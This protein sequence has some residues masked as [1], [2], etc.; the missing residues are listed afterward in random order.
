VAAVGATLRKEFATS[1]EGIRQGL[2]QLH[3]DL[4]TTAERIA[5]HEHPPA[6]ATM[7]PELEIALRESAQRQ[8]ALLYRHLAEVREALDEH[9]APPPRPAEIPDVDGFDRIEDGLASVTGELRE[10]R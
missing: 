7:T 2:E 9:T 1:A 4:S 5:G 8:E 6:A 10:L 3:L